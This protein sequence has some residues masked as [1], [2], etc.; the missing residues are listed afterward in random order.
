MYKALGNIYEYLV[1]LFILFFSKILQL[2]LQTAM[3]TSRPQKWPRLFE[4]QIPKF[5]WPLG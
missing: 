2:C 3:R 5:K 1:G 4:Q